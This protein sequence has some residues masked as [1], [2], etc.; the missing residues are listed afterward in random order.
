MK[1]RIVLEVGGTDTNDWVKVSMINKS[2][3]FERRN[4]FK[5]L[6]KRKAYGKELYIAHVICKMCAVYNIGEFECYRGS[7][8]IDRIPVRVKM[9][10]RSGKTRYTTYG[11]GTYRFHN[12]YVGY[13]FHEYFVQYRKRH[14]NTA[15][16]LKKITEA[17]QM[18][19][20]IATDATWGVYGSTVHVLSIDE[21]EW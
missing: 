11:N 6:Y 8:R 18:K 14:K 10:T 12:R 19:Q 21:S 5:D 1:A 4:S 7:S 2:R 16:K 9:K 17:Q 3:V 20:Q 15:K 13:K